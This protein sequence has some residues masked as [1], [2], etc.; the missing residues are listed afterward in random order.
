MPK[1]KAVQ[2]Q[3]NS[4][5][6]LTLA[7]LLSARLDGS[8]LELPPS[9]KA[10]ALLAYLA[11]TRRPQRREHLVGLLWNE[12]ED[13]REGLRWCLSRL[14]KV[15]EPDGVSRLS[16]D[17]DTVALIPDRADCDI[18][19]L[20]KIGTVTPT[21]TS[22]TDLLAAADLAQGD[23]LAGLNLPDCYEFR[24]WCMAEREN[25]R[26]IQAAILATLCD[27]LGVGDQ[28]LAYARRRVVLEPD[29][30]TAHLA[31]L[32]LLLALGRQPEA[33]AHVETARRQFE[34]A[35]LA[36]PHR[37]IRRWADRR[38]APR[39]PAASGTSA[40]AGQKVQFCITGDGVRIAYAVAGSGPRL[41]KTANWLSHLEHDQQ[42]PVWQHL[43]DTLAHGRQLVRYDRRGGG[44]SDWSCERFGFG[45]AILDA[46]AVIGALDDRPY[47]LFGLSGGCAIAVALAA[48][49]PDRVRR[50]IL[51]GGSTLGF[52]RRTKPERET[53]EALV[54]LTRQGWGVDNPA[55]RQ[56]FTSMM[57]P[58]A[59][60]EQCVWFNDLQRVS[61]SPENAARIMDE[62]GLYDVT[63]YLAEVRCPTLV[64]HSRDDAMVS[65]ELGR[66]LAAGIPNAQ[67]VSLPSRNHIILESEP[68]W[69][70]LRAEI[71]A[72]LAD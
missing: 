54:A 15:L 30:E 55:F 41:L 17:R 39:P 28:A 56:V 43:I 65:M 52:H 45:E 32:D 18:W 23:F 5:L 62:F 47:D 12:T 70:I 1:P 14:R 36:P 6:T 48:R 64:L 40:A 33:E 24:L 34:A 11:V 35:G 50:M 71:E 60:P 58:D 72:F 42:S 3:P 57:F 9:K 59:T 25:L 31:L 29:E 61:A 10:R 16:A 20:Q 37:L 67:F 13:G 66:Q 27:R 7:G 53:R 21:A 44:L 68:A 38:T 4:K 26:R 69:A 8:A 51:M 63:D 46:E 19:A 2:P 22:T 49:H